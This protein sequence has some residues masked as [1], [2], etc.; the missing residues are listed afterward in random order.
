M[1]IMFPKIM[2]SLSWSRNFKTSGSWKRSWISGSWK[3]NGMI[4]PANEML[5]SGRGI[6][7]VGNFVIKI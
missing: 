7:G 3:D 2:A 5:L 1:K 6:W 4:S